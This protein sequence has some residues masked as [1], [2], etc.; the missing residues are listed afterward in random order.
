LDASHA[1]YQN[2]GTT[3]P[4]VD[5]LKRRTVT[6]GQR[7]QTTEKKTI[8]HY[9]LLPQSPSAMS[10]RTWEQIR[11]FLLAFQPVCGFSLEEACQAEKV[12]IL[13]EAAPAVTAM[14]LRDNG[15]AVEYLAADRI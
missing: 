8:R 15:C 14:R 4:L 7:T 6:K 12:T 13:G 11:G 2:D 9:L 10:G 3:L 1:W 5:L